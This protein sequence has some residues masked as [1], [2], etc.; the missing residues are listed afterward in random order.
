MY[1]GTSDSGI[2]YLR[3]ASAI[4]IVLTM[5]GDGHYVRGGDGGRSQ[6]VMEAFVLAIASCYHSRLI[7]SSL[8][9]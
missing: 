6:V 5:V 9:R 1:T 8:L 4:S 2:S 3:Y 7:S